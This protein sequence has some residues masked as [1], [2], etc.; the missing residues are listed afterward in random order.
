MTTKLTRWFAAIIAVL[1]IT[2][3]SAQSNI[4]APLEKLF[5]LEGRWQGPTQF[6][7]GGT[8]FDFTYYLEFKRNQ[9]NS[10]LTMIETFTHADI[11]TLVG[12]NLIGYNSRDEKI[13]WFS[14][15]N[16]GTTHDHLGYWISDDHFY[17]ETT[18]KHGGKK[19][20]EKIDIILISPTQ[21]S[22][23][24]VATVGGIVVQDG[25][26]VFTKQANP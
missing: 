10:G 18:E 3:A 21:I 20:E 7:L 1:S 11:G 22:L 12:Y 15:D 16:F 24:L 17:M 25:S 8:V 2:A 6:N 9:E 23:H 13:H 4:P 14:V 19:F 5:S 26:G